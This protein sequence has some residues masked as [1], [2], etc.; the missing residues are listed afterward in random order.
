M[1][2]WVVRGGKHGEYEEV[3]LDNGLACLGFQ[4]VPN[5]TKAKTRDAVLQLVQEAYPN[6]SPRRVSNFRAQVFAFAH[7]MDKG[8]LVV[9]PL[10]GQ[11]Q[12]AIGRVTGDYTYRND[13]ADIHHVRP[14]QWVNTY[15]RS[16]LN[17]DLLRSM[18]ARMT[19]FQVKR[20]N[21]VERVNAVLQGKQDPGYQAATV[22]SDDEAVEDTGL[23]EIDLDQQAR[24]EIRAYIEENFKGH[25]LA[26]LV[27]SVLKAAGYV[28]QRAEPGPDGGVDILARHGPLGFE[29]GKLCVQVKSSLSQTDSDIFRQ[30]VGSMANFQA[31]EGLLVSWGGFNRPMLKEA[32]SRFFS[33]RLWDADNLIEAIEQSFDRLPEDIKKELPLKRIWALVVEEQADSVA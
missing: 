27:D 13:L 30:F 1:K 23:S 22:D 10:K 29:G 9:M 33:V 17:Q 18:G 24:D 5:L 15:A 26:R 4:E 2:L 28:T 32:R 25:D 3:A 7:L 31:D 16:Q 8:D 11:P 6:D 14:V 20:N 19:V 21:A 12:L